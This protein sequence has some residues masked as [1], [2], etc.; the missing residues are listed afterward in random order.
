MNLISVLNTL[1]FHKKDIQ[2]I[3]KDRNIREESVLM[4]ALR[5]YIDHARMWKQI[6]SLWNVAG[7]NA[8]DSLKVVFKAY[9]PVSLVGDVL[10][11]TCVNT[12]YTNAHFSQRALLQCIQG[13]QPGIK[14]IAYT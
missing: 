7:R 10:V 12:T 11:L 8:S 1:S 2:A 14:T 5:V 3:A 9:R 13:V 6:D 4:E